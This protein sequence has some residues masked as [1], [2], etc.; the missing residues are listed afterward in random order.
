MCVHSQASFHGPSNKILHVYVQ[1]HAS[2]LNN[3]SYSSPACALLSSCLLLC[4]LFLFSVSNSYTFYLPLPNP[5]NSIFLFVYPCLLLGFLQKSSDA[6]LPLAS[7]PSS[8]AAEKN[9]LEVLWCAYCAVCCVVCCAVCCVLLLCVL[10][11][12]IY[13]KC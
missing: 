12:L 10:L 2:L 4:F 5:F 6:A 1:C 3:C 8:Q 9:K 11:C 13:I 7:S